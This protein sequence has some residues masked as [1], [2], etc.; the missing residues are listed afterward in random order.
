MQ[1]Q[2]DH[3]HAHQ[4]MVGRL[5]S[6]LVLGDPSG[7]E[8]P[9]RRALTGLIIGVLIAA[10]VV[11]GFGV[12]GWIVPG[13]SKAYRQPGLILVEKETG[14]RYVY[15]DGLL[16]SVP[17]LPA[18]LLLQG[19]DAKVKL[20]S[21]AS[22]ASVPRGLTMG[23]P[24]GPRTVPAPE[25]FVSGPWLACLPDKPSGPGLALDLDP[26]APHTPIPPERLTVVRDRS[27]TVHLLTKGHR[28][29]V[30]DDAV[31]IALGVSAAS[32]ALAPESWLSHIPA[33]VDLQPAVISGKGR[34]G[35]MVAGR[36]YDIGT[37]FRQSAGTGGEQFFVLQADGLASMSH[38]E[39]L[40]AAVRSRSE[41]VTLH[42]ADLLTAPR[43]AD[44]SLLDRL[45]EL[46]GVT[47]HRLDDQVLCLRQAPTSATTVSSVLVEAP[48][49]AVP[50]D[51]T[52]R[53]TVRGPAGGAMAVVGVPVA[54][55]RTPPVYLVSSGGVAFLMKDPAAVAA[56]KI[57]Q[58]RPVPFPQELLAALRQGPT[59]SREAVTVIAEG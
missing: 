27:D 56:L 18:A 48:R 16:H 43:S 1:T 37:L 52:G 25:L 53:G 29:R 35:P 40:F 19:A 12:Y 36:S 22:L 44:R 59:L 58:V 4:F 3:V 51:E 50:V 9:G 45:P 11:A 39:F 28:Y 54:Q 34:A 26:R 20:V 21:R 8:V 47:V 5:S 31:L 10:L 2:R 38:T 6:A 55:G 46:A 14:T 30:T 33:G 57:N 42:G 15:A 23:I 13:G 17:D 49:S 41:P 24:D 7:A 32:V